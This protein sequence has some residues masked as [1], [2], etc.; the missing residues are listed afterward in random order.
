MK[1]NNIDQFDFSLFGNRNIFESNE[2][3]VE[4]YTPMGPIR[5]FFLC[6]KPTVLLEGPAGT[7]KTRGALEKFHLWCEKYPG[8][9]LALTRKLRVDLT[10][11]ALISFEKDVL[12]SGHEALK[13]P[14]K[15]RRTVYRYRNGSELHVFGLTDRSHGEDGAEKLKSTEWDGII[16]EE[17]TENSFADYQ[18][19]IS[20]LRNGTIAFPQLVICFNPVSTLHWVYQLKRENPESV[21]HFKTVHH[22]NPAY[23]REDAHGTVVHPVTGVPGNWTKL[24]YDY[25]IGKL[26]ILKGTARE[27]FFL[28]KAIPP[29]GIV[30][31][32]FDSDIHVT[33]SLLD[34]IEAMPISPKEKRQ[35][36]LNNYLIYISADWGSGHPCVIQLWFV[37]KIA[38]RVMEF[39][40]TGSI[41]DEAGIE[42]IRAC[43][44]EW[45]DDAG[46]VSEVEYFEEE[47]YRHLG[48]MYSFKIPI[49]NDEGE[50]TC[51][52]VTDHSTESRD[53]F[54]RG[55]G[56]DTELAVKHVLTGIEEVRAGLRDKLIFLDNVEPIGGKD[57]AQEG[58]FAPTSTIQEPM[59]YKLG[60]YMGGVSQMPV[61]LHDDGLSALRYFY[62]LWRGVFDKEPK[63]ED[64]AN[65]NLTN[66]KMYDINENERPSNFGNFTNTRQRE[67]LNVN[68]RELSTLFDAGRIR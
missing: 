64:F 59:V 53:L 55:T 12:P 10:N 56:L 35:Y 9:R 14:S 44:Y 57:P 43:G 4:L 62:C 27:R 29:S 68:G 26:S 19:A 51:I 63:A 50:Q 24:G 36:I 18:M 67:L 22:D 21:I 46:R 66:A 17:G 39:Y 32:E 20:R 41:S 5:D 7:G 3:K 16:F 37:S 8:I 34:E 2:E 61:R 38:R 54:T 11:S 31:P 13:G 15:E 65:P 42:F 25:V 23:W 52:V 40:R 47:E 49:F 6:K 33:S 58:K 48:R 45:D 30:Y 28:G 60:K 1:T